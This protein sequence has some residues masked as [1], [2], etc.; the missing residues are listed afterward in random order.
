MKATRVDDVMIMEF[1]D[2]TKCVFQNAFCHCHGQVFLGETEE[3]AVKVL[4]N[5]HGL[6]GNDVFDEADMV[7]ITFQPF[8]YAWKIL[9][10]DFVDIL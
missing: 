1:C 8:V 6:I 5:E 3:M 4:E 2:S 9:E 10:T 7:S